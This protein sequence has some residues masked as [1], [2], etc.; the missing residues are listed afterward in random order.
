MHTLQLLLYL[1][2]V[3]GNHFFLQQNKLT[4]PINKM[5][6]SDKSDWSYPPCRRPN[7]A[8]C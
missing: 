7:W 2:I 8:A 6:T 5:I 4:I 1:V 3:F